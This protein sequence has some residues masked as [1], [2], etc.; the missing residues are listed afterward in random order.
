MLAALH[1]LLLL[2]V[3]A[4]VLRNTDVSICEGNYHSQMKQSVFD[5][6]K[7]AMSSI[8]TLYRYIPFIGIK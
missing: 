2:L 4:V 3:C 8:I 6:T 7:M 1:H 5:L